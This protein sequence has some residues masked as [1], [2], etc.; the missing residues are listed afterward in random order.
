MALIFLPTLGSVF[1]RKG[2]TVDAN[3]AVARLNAQEDSDPTDL[4]GLTG[5]YART[6]A[7]L[8]KRPAMVSLG[9]LIIVVG[10]VFS[11][12]ATA[13]NMRTEFFLDAEP[14]QLYVFVRARGNLSP[15]EQYELALEAET[16]LQDIEGI[17]GYYTVAGTP[18]GRSPFDGV[19][20]AP[21][22]TVAR[23]FVEFEPFGQR[24]NGR[25]IER[26]IRE[27]MVGIPGVIIE[28][29]PSSRARLSARTSRSNCARMTPPRWKLRHDWCVVSSTRW[30]AR[31][32]L[33]TPCPSRALSGGWMSIARR[34]VALAPMSRSW[35]QP[36][37]W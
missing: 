11:F 32:I 26:E 27:A 31:R 28:V 9:A 22:D 6:I 24:P 14:E 8:V 20:A 15:T 16:R 18:P 37:N 1:G 25:L 3:S 33:T 13:S 21:A 12:G 5:I 34:P 36:Y 10:V 19:G 7:R 23:I 2:G 30:T 17:K 4:P 29:R 35:V